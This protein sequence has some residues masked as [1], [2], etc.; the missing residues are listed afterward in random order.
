MK[1]GDSHVLLVSRGLFHVQDVRDREVAVCSFAKGVAI[2]TKK[3]KIKNRC[4]GIHERT[5][6]KRQPLLSVRAIRSLW[7][8][9]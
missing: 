9:S 3:Q 6:A 7:F 2:G 5:S 8:S 1:R 4:G